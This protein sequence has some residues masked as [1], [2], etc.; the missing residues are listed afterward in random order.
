M[1]FGPANAVVFD[2][3]CGDRGINCTKAAN[4]GETPK[5]AKD[6]GSSRNLG[7]ATNPEPQAIPY[8]LCDARKQHK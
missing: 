7:E 5:P 6:H 4:F 3:S 2:G 8:V 1:P